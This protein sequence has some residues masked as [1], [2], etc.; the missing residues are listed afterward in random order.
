MI[1]HGTSQRGPSRLARERIVYGA[2]TAAAIAVVLATIVSAVAPMFADLSTLGGH[3][4]DEMEAQRWLVV[5]SIREFHQFPFWNPY[6]CGGFSGWAAVESDT[7]VVS[8]FLP[9]Y[10]FAPLAWA[11]RVEVVGA[12]IISALGAWLFAGRFTRSAA[13]R[14]FVC[15]IFAV[16]GRWAMQTATGHAWHLYYAYTPWVF[17][18]FDKAA[19]GDRKSVYL[20]GAVVALMVYAGAIY[21]LPQTALLVAIYA[22]ALAVMRRDPTPVAVGAAVGAIGAGLAAPKLVSMLE[23]LARWPRL[24]DSSESIDLHA[25]VQILID[26]NQDISLPAAPVGPWGWHEYGMYIGWVPF[27][28]TLAGVVFAK[29]PR[30]RALRWPA[31]AA[32]LLG[33]GHF[34]PFSPWAKLHEWPI[35]KSQHVPTRWLYP[36]VLLCGVVAASAG[37]RVLARTR[38]LRAPLELGLIVAVAFIGLDIAAVAGRS[39]QHAFWMRMRPVAVARQY[40]MERDVP[41]E[42]R[43]EVGDYAPPALPATLAGIGVI[44]CTLHPGLN[45]FAA[46]ASAGGRPIGLGALGREE[47]GYR[48]EAYTASGKGTASVVRFSP[49]RIDVTLASA[50]V[51]DLLVLNQNWDSGWKAD[52]ARTIPYRDAVAIPI[53]KTQESVTFS[54]RPHLF[55][56][57]LCGPLLVLA[58]VLFGPRIRRSRFFEAQH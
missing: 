1:A 38:W 56:L 15:V 49:N 3:D 45:I 11:V 51:G 19:Q 47:P 8:P 24:T 36:A 17:F 22:G 53:T 25:F 35:F 40:H 12:A 52:G 23:D 30:A 28:A 44:D 50:Q 18:L 34:H 10:L 26:R 31:V 5:K 54:Y 55:W 21:P 41:Q 20:C 43:Y 33:F 39:V 37:E 14:A 27:V 57:T 13:L 6:A 2:L 42:L 9:V 46:P 16:N 32:V 48:G 4:W 29:D 58:A 7:I